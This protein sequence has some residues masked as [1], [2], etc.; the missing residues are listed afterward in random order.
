ML[1][2]YREI[3]KTQVSPKFRIGADFGVADEPERGEDQ[4]DDNLGHRRRRLQR[5]LEHRRA[6]SVDES[7]KIAEVTSLCLRCKAML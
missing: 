3:S 5:L 1:S 4:A 2:P 7:A 6:T